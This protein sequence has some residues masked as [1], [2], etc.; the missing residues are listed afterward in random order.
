MRDPIIV[1]IISAV[2]ALGAG[3]GLYGAFTIRSTRRNLEAQANRADAEVITL[4][5][6]ASVD[7]LKPLQERV[8]F[9]TAQVD[10]ATETLQRWH[11]LIHQ[12]GIDLLRLRE[13]IRA[14]R[15]AERLR[16]GRG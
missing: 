4:L 12:D 5:G 6:K 15:E 1:A 14:D 3:G 13:A 11:A 9:L 2:A 8:D 10:A 7:M 16:N